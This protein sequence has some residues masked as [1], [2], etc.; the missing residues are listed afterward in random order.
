MFNAPNL[1]PE[2]AFFSH[3]NSSKAARTTHDEY[4]HPHIDTEQYGTFAV[5]SILY[6]NSHGTDY[7]GGGFRFADNMAAAKEALGAPQS[8]N[9]SWSVVEPAIGRAVAFTSGTENVHH[10]EPVTRGTRLALTM[11]FTCNAAKAASIERWEGGPG[12]G[13]EEG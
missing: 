13:Y 6:L 1:L 11:A 7:E 2:M 3:I 9:A 8:A 12:S 5:T 10:V 4:W